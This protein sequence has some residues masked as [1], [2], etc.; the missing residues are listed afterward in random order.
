MLLDLKL[1]GINWVILCKLLFSKLIFPLSTGL[2]YYTLSNIA[3]RF[4][5][6]LNVIQLVAVVKTLLIEKYGIKEILKPFIQGVR[7]LESVSIT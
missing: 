3:P 2:F 1:R 7:Q 5:S 4:R 6:S